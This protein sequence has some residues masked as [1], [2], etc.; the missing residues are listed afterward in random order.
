MAPGTQ[1]AGSRLDSRANFDAVI[2]L[3]SADRE[4]YYAA[5]QIGRGRE[6]N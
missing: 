2:D 6:S 3:A 4:A 1:R 5:H